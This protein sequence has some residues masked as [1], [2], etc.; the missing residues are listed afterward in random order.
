VLAVAGWFSGRL[1]EAPESN[2]RRGAPAPRHGE[3]AFAFPLVSAAFLLWASGWWLWGGL[4]EIERFVPAR[5]ELAAS[6]VFVAATTLLAMVAAARAGWPRLNALGLVLWPG[7]I[8]GAVVAA[9]DMSHP[10]EDLG[11]FAWPAAI[12]AMLGFLRA[13]EA[14]YDALRPL[15]HTA[16]Y[17]LAG[18]LLVWET[19]WLVDRMAD[20]IWPAAAALAAGTALVLGTL[21]LRG[22]I[23]W[24]LAA[25]AETYIKLCC[26]GALAALMLATIVANAVSPGDSAPLPYLPLL[27]PLEIVSVFVCIVL[28]RWLA[29]LQENV[30]SLGLDVRHRAVVAGVFGWYLLTM[31]VARAV[32]R[33]E[34]VPFDFDSL[35]A[36]MVMQSSLSIV[37]GAT[38]LSAMVIGARRK[39]RVVWLTGAA[40]MAVVVGK[41][42]LLE[43]GSSGTLPRIVSF[44]GVGLLLLVVGYFAPVPPRT[45]QGERAA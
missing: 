10:A 9:F 38:A 8:V 11:W 13:R 18:V 30:P 15:L 3:S 34:P 7:A 33:W 4:A 39:R 16:A 41:L 25:H 6:L 42:F 45:E 19:H 2:A 22:R 31:A 37:W 44:L 43:L 14:R 27:N 36:S 35:M 40:L 26:G 32:H 28:L 17:W 24:P 20:G 1:F 21:R 29:V 12:A 23:A 5:L